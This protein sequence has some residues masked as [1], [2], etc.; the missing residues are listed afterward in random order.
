MLIEGN[1]T[2]DAHRFADAMWSFTCEDWWFTGRTD[3]SVYPGDLTDCPDNYDLPVT[4]EKRGARVISV[5]RLGAIGANSADDALLAMLGSAQDSIK[6]SLQDL[7]PPKVGPIDIA[8]WPEEVLGE[9]A[10][11][12]LRGV[13]IHMVLSTAYSIPGGLTFASATYGNGWEPNDVLERVLEWM[14][15]HPEYVPTGTNSR[16]LLCEKFNIAKLRF[17]EDDT[18]SDNVGIGNHSKFFVV[19]D[20]AF[21]LGS[22]N[23]YVSN[24]S[25]FGLIIDDQ[26]VTADILDVYFNPAWENSKRV[27][28]SG[29]EASSCDF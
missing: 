4:K 26:E 8:P 19:D 25:E 1:V 22:Q 3:R 27:A 10:K 28:I 13:E 9:L 14:E 29:S 23:F 7:G 17:S 6:L 5:G 20:Q 12:L 16:A 24:L 11:A 2:V 21:Y 15:D 18:W